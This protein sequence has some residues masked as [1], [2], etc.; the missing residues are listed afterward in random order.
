MNRD[1]ARPSFVVSDETAEALAVLADPATYRQHLAEAVRELAVETDTPIELLE[2]IAAAPRAGR[3]LPAV[4]PWV[5]D[6]AKWVTLS[7][8][9]R[10]ALERHHRKVTGGR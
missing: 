3:T 1:G 9:D 7:R 4:P 10:R 6:P 8:A 2:G 5:T